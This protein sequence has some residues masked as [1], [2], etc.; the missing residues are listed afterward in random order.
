MIVHKRTSVPLDESCEYRSEFE[1]EP[2]GTSYSMTSIV[3]NPSVSYES[4]SL[5]SRQMSMGVEKHF[6]FDYKIQ[7]LCLYFQIRL[8]A[9]C[10]F[11]IR[12]V[13]MK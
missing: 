7:Q 1:L 4:V 8:H 13:L 10:V 11:N 3:A 2:L 12:C 6:A 9:L 5:V